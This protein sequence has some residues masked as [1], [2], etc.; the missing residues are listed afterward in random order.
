MALE[1]YEQEINRTILKLCYKSCH[2]YF[3][4]SPQ[5]TFLILSLTPPTL[6]PH[7]CPQRV[8]GTRPNPHS[9]CSSPRSVYSECRL[10]AVK[11]AGNH[12]SAGPN[13]GA[14]YAQMTRQLL[15]YEVLNVNHT[16]MLMVLYFITHFY[17]TKQMYMYF[18]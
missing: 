10:P 11:V 6:I 2:V 1:Q 8:P 5:S 15:L 13:T 18:C 7:Y 9:V 3:Q 4:E 14:D 12:V 16:F 17:K